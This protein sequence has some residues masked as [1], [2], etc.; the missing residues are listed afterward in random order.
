MPCICRVKFDGLLREKIK[1]TEAS[2]GV[3]NALLFK[4]N[5]LYAESYGQVCSRD[6]YTLAK[7]D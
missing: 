3:R 5:S 7:C 6:S 1:K 4:W 2:Y